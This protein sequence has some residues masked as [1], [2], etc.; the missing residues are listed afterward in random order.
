M[1]QD[2]FSHVLSL[3]TWREVLS[4]E[5]RAHLLTLLPSGVDSDELLRSVCTLLQT[6]KMIVIVYNAI[7]CVMGLLVL[8]SQSHHHPTN[9]Y[10]VAVVKFTV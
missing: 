9:Q 3:D 7:M 10:T 2:V 4:E 6:R 1:Q 8:L 5:E